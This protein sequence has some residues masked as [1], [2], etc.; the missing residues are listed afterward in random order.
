VKEIALGRRQ[1]IR[2]DDGSGVA[3]SHDS[4]GQECDDDVSR[5]SKYVSH[6]STAFLNA[7][8]CVIMKEQPFGAQT[9][10]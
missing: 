5:F 2:D 4:Q 9:E 6:D 10:R 1:R 8:V 7:A 3:L